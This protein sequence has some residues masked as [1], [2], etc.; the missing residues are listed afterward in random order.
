MTLA[1]IQNKQAS[2]HSEMEEEIIKNVASR[3]WTKEQLRTELAYLYIMG[4]R[5]GVEDAR[6]ASRTVD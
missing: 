2:E 1:D 3:K 4:I 5:H 6:A